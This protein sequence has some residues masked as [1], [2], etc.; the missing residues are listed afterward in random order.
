MYTIEIATSDF[1]TT[2]AAVEG[3]AHRIELCAN[4][5][6]GGTTP[7]YGH[8]RRC[9]EAFA[10]PIWPII[11]PRGGDFLYNDVEFD[12]MKMDISLCRDLGCDGIVTGL[13]L[14]G[15]EVDRDRLQQLMEL[16]YPMPVTFHRAF[17]RC[18]DPFDA[19]ETL[20]ELGVERIL[21]SGQQPTAPEGVSLIKEL[22]DKAASRITILP[23]SGVRP[24]NIRFLAE[25]TGCNEFH[26]S[27]RRREPSAMQFR[28]PAFANDPDSYE[29]N[30]ID[31][32]EVTALIAALDN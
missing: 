9:R 30:S 8:I 17:D 25:H 1:L 18:R 19:M 4:L 10:L 3:G 13:L 29:N 6:E 5:A 24:E 23:G 2:Q 27:L 11:R 22:Q 20:I 31:V 7:G 12:I 32:A 16:A 21:T 14:P 28:H 26:A 15:G